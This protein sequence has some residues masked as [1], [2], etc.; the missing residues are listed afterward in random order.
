MNKDQAT[1]KKKPSED[2]T[3]LSSQPSGLSV[4]SLVMGILSLTGFGLILGIPAI[5]TG[6]MALRRSAA[7]RGLSWAGIITGSI[8]TAISLLLLILFIIFIIVAAVGAGSYIPY[9]QMQ[10]QM[11]PTQV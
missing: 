4:V 9:E 6:V 5:I 11:M 3:N 2:K 10:G 7:D 8:S 1:A